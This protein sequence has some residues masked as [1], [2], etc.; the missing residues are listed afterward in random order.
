MRFKLTIDS[1]NAGVTPMAVA[2]YFVSIGRRMA[3][4]APQIEGAV[5]SQSGRVLDDNGNTIGQWEFDFGDT[6]DSEAN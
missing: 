6:H 3:A 1:D 5:G 4:I 2:G